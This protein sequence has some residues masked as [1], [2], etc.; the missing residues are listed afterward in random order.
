MNKFFNNMKMLWQKQD[1]KK[2]SSTKEKRYR[3][4]NK[5]SQDILT[6]KYTWAE[7]KKRLVHD[8]VIKRNEINRQRIVD[9]VKRLRNTRMPNG[10]Y[11]TYRDLERMTGI[12]KTEIGDILNGK[13]NAKYLSK[14]LDI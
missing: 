12:S 2:I 1:K 4:K 14:R 3:P 11:P 10:K 7:H 5:H 9:E 6:T 13:A 8:E